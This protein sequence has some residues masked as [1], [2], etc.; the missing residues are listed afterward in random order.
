MLSH[1]SL[2]NS[3]LPLIRA[4]KWGTAWPCTSRGIKYTTGQIKKIWNLCDRNRTWHHCM[5]GILEA[6]PFTLGRSRQCF[7]LFHLPCHCPILPNRHCLCM[8]WIKKRE[9]WNLINIPPIYLS[10]VAMKHWN[11]NIAIKSIFELILK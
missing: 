5:F 1:S 3:N 6:F 7:F 11:S 2:Q 10:N 4:F 8:Y 9:L